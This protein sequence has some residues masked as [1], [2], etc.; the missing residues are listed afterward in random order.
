MVDKEPFDS[1]DTDWRCCSGSGERCP[2]LLGLPFDLR[3]LAKSMFSLRWRLI[4]LA[5]SSVSFRLLSSTLSDSKAFRFPTIESMLKE[6]FGL[7]AFMVLRIVGE[8]EI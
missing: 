7:E 2:A 5:N 4:D 8:A 6:S 3:S 1:G